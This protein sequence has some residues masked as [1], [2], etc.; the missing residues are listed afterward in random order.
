MSHQGMAKHISAASM[1][2]G[3]HPCVV[4]LHDFTFRHISN[5]AAVR[6]TATYQ[7]LYSSRTAAP[8]HAGSVDQKRDI[9]QQ[10][11]SIVTG[12]RP[13][14]VLQMV[15]TA[16]CVCRLVNRT[17]MVEH[18]QLFLCLSHQSCGSSYA[19]GLICFCLYL[20][21]ELILHSSMSVA[22]SL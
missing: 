10:L 12:Q 19:C 2:S 4:Q 8:V 1:R 3:M 6:Q 7:P 5:A 11:M 9:K 16:Q 21:L 22:R 14:S 18:L 20:Y 13:S 17:C 15:G